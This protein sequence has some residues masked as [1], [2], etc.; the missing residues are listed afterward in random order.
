MRDRERSTSVWGVVLAAGSGDRFGGQKQFLQVRGHRLVD[1]AV[2][3]T[4][5][6][7]DEVIL[8]VPQ[9]T[10]WHGPEVT[11]VI[12][13]GESRSASVRRALAVLPP[14]ADITV[15]HQ[16]AHPLA[17]AALFTAVI[18]CVRRGAS[19]AIPGLRPTDVIYR[20]SDGGLVESVGRDDLV[21]VQT[22]GAFR[23][24]VLRSAH[25]SGEEA[26]E[27]AALVMALGEPVVVVPGEVSNVHV[28]TPRDL[29]LV[30]RMLG[31]AE[32]HA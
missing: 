31:S 11:Q 28:T 9:G 8:V 1:M 4:K 30:G 21:I 3:S 5:Q 13:G 17:S 24:D 29:T 15:V 14:D 18:R 7:C 25:A 10:T 26:I 23:T 32:L 2:A 22:P 6:A 19:A 20:A 12:V 16:A 27:D